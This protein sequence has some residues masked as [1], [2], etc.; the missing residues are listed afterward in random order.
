MKLLFVHQNFPGQF[1]HLAHA[2]GERGWD[3]TAICAA[4][5]PGMAGVRLVRY[6]PLADKSHAVHPWARDLHVKAIRA[7]VV[8]R[9]ALRLREAGYVPDLIYGHP[10]WG[11]CLLL[12]DIFPDTPQ[13]NFLEFYY[14]AAGADVGFDPEFPA[15]APW[16][17]GRLRFKN[18]VLREAL[19]TMD[20]G[21]AP[22]QWQASLLP[23]QWRDR[24]SVIFDGIDTDVVR[25]DAAAALQLASGPRLTRDDEVITFVSRNLEPYR[26]FHVFMR[27]LPELLRRRPRAHVL[28]IGGDGVSYG[29]PPAD[30][31]SW[32]E[33]L[34]REVGAALDPARLHFLGRVPYAQYLKV[35]QLSRVHVYLTY[36]FVLSWSLVE[37]M[38]AGCA[39]VAS[40]TV[41]VREFL[42]HECTARL[43]PFF[44]GVALVEQVCALLDAPAAAAAL[45]A[46]ARAD[47]VA[48]HDLRRVCLPQLVDLAERVARRAPA[49]ASPE[50]AA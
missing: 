34:L 12:K 33:V 18:M 50:T 27:A 48:R 29:T 43:F 30:G 9:E 4:T 23:P 14:R 49:Q 20:W 35:L 17:A 26:G 16:T 3:M 7:E 38:S 42:A 25:P 11:E 47:A 36:P 45:G 32:R 41:P 15:P 19:E 28:A 24:V 5:A 46:A 44:D 8:A 6:P 13:L 1:V 39:I 10:G 22:T 40:D 21:V 37:A 2:G 31:G